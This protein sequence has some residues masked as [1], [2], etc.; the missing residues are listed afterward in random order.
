MECGSLEQ[1]LNSSAV[2]ILDSNLILR[3]SEFD[4][5][6]ILLRHLY[7]CRSLGKVSPWLLN[8]ALNYFEDSCPLFDFPEVY[9][10][11][12]VV[13]ETSYVLECIEGTIDFFKSGRK[14]F[15]KNRR[16]S[17]RSCEE[18]EE[19]LLDIRTIVYQ[20]IS[21]M[22]ERKISFD[23]SER[24]RFNEIWG[25]LINLVKQNKLKVDSSSKYNTPKSRKIQESYNDEEIV[26][27][28]LILAQKGAL[29]KIVSDDLD[30]SRIV[31]YVAKN[32]NRFKPRA[33]MEIKGGLGVFR[34]DRTFR[35]FVKMTDIP[36]FTG[37]KFGEGI[38]VG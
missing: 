13:K 38:L 1:V 24:D 16:E 21:A 30:I 18:K 37:E 5:A 3:D 6:G 26:A 7:D 14:M 27:T 19:L 22:K 29:V 31:S 20:V 32:Y 33:F 35:E 25:E 10:T 17:K 28:G 8:R 12:G 36:R 2:K 15:D 23:N 34:Y 9:F 4:C 11:E